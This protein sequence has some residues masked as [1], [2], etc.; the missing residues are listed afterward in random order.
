VVLGKKGDIQG[1]ERRKDKTQKTLEDVWGKGK[2]KNLKEKHESANGGEQKEKKQ[3]VFDM[4]A[5]F[6][7]G[8]REVAPFKLILM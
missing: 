8:N 4:N 7:G 1:A 3:N 2:Q 5:S 6:K